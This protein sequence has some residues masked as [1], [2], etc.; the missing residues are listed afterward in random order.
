[1]VDLYLSAN[2]KVIREEERVKI[3]LP[4]PRVPKNVDYNVYKLN[5]NSEV[6]IIPNVHTSNS[7]KYPASSTPN[8]ITFEMTN[9]TSEDAGFYSVGYNIQ[10]SRTQVGIILVVKGK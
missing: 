8:S 4:I 2:V 6:K 3:T 7:L 10:N 9:V 1:M 5:A